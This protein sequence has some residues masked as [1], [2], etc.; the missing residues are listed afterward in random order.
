[1]ATITTTNQQPVILNSHYLDSLANPFDPAALIA[2][3]VVKPLY[4]PLM[5]G[6]PVT[7]ARDNKPLSEQDI[8]NMLFACST[9]VLDPVAE[10]ETKA[11]LAQTLAYYDT[12]LNV[13]DVYA[14]QA[15]KAQNMLMPSD[16]VLYTPMDVID[17]S[18][19]LLGGQI[20]PEG[21]FATIAFYARVQSLG[22]YFANEIAWTE[23]KDW[24]MNEIN[25][26]QSIIPPDTYSLCQNLMQIRL[27]DLTESFVL[28]DDDSQNNDPY[29][30]A[31]VFIFYLM[32]YEQN[33]KQNNQPVFTMGHMP[34]SFAETFCPRTIIILNVEK[35]AHARPDQ[36]KAE[37]DTIK[38]SMTMKPKVLGRNQLMKL[39]SIAKMAK[40]MSMSTAM[41]QSSMLT[42]SAVIKF[43]KT[44]PTSVDLYKY[45]MRIYKN[46]VFIQNSENAVH[47]KKSSYQ[48]PNRRHPDDIDKMGVVTRTTYKPDLHIYLDC[49]GSI[50]EREY[51]DA[52][53]A[54]IK[55][56]KKMN[57]NFYFNSFS[58][59]MSASTKLH[60]ANKSLKDIY[61]EFK[62]TPKVGGGTDYE[63]IWH[64]INRSKKLGREVSIII[65]D[66]EW[67]APNHY[68]K[69]PRF[70]Y[71]AP[72]STSNWS[73]ITNAAKYFCQ[74]M[75]NLCPKIRT[76][77]LM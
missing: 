37:W 60:V 9:D 16:K 35:H 71:Y 61:R 1:M 48:K 67:T 72:I 32:L 59:I 17:A 74:S 22:F 31:R 18:K 65:S 11:V 28:R 50:S 64:Y 54:C 76:K 12:A 34:F 52:I 75:L 24:F 41:R 49:S 42:R 36:I 63:Q 44:A 62:N 23:F 68:V 43:R 14:V 56:A 4:T 26:I 57:V 69:H 73:M 33:M 40:K 19:Q 51:Q 58:H 2:D 29:S 13:Q 55:L 39:T 46:A 45:I 77:V 15:G 27:T 70:L 5:P 8:T 38:A 66:F 10:N 3:N 53:K 21:F 30:F 25:Q 7:I 6:T 47:C 20:R